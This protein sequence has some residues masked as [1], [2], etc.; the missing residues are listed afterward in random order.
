M[1][2][3]A[4]PGFYDAGNVND[5]IRGFTWTLVLQTGSKPKLRCSAAQARALIPFGKQLVQSFDVTNPEELAAKI[6]MEHLFECY[7]ALRGGPG[8]AEKL[9]L[10]SRL[11]AVQAVALEAHCN[12]RWSVKPKLHQFLELCSDGNLPSTNWNYQD[13][14]FGGMCSRMGRR[15]GGQLGPKATSTNLISRFKLRTAFPRLVGRRRFNLRPAFSRLEGGHIYIYIYI[16]MGS[17]YIY[18]YTHILCVHLYITLGGR[19]PR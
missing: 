11:F 13:E 16:Y 15:R 8:F 4:H 12:A 19:R 17:T 14:D 10:H 18:I 7:E 5:R 1:W 6:A 9:K 3:Y 2:P